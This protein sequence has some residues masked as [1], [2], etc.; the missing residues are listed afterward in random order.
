MKSLT[1]L[2]S[3]S[4]MEAVRKLDENGHGFLAIVDAN[5]KLIGILT[6]GDVRR[7]FL[8]EKTS[9]CDVINKD[10]LVMLQGSSKE[11]ILCELR[12]SHKRHMP[13]VDVNRVLVDVFV[14]DNFD[15]S[16]KPNWVVI[17]AGGLGIR[18]GSLT[19]DIPKPML[20]LGGKPILERVIELFKYFGYSKFM[21]SVNYKSEIIKEYF[22][23][24]EEF[25]I[26][27]KYI[28]ESKKM[29]TIGSL[30]LIDINIEDPFFVVNGDVIASFDCDKLLA[31]H[32]NSGAT[33]TMCVKENKI[34]IPYGVVDV[35]PDSRIMSL[36]EKPVKSYYINAGIYVM[37]PDALSLIKKDLYLDAP[38][39][40]NILLDKSEIVTSF[41]V[42]D[43]WMDLGVPGDYI[44]VAQKFNL[45]TE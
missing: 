11:K 45:M 12:K 37:N 27:I 32:V 40:F 6:D 19:R 41:L 22:G 25:G 8:D 18:L 15:F 17:M 31:S 4:L 44:D 14:L 36:K 3:A 39:L 5:N 28:E 2:Y 16:L 1:A 33:A 42:E 21:I 38:D 34:K 10:P 26:E 24:G 23:S 35:G 30:G 43:Y 7:G 9:L 20:D 29:G 13:I